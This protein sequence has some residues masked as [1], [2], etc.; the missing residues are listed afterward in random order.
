MPLDRD[1]GISFPDEHQKIS[2]LV[3][4]I[5][6]QHGDEHGLLGKALLHLNSSAIAHQYG[7][8]EEAQGKLLTAQS[9]VE[10]AMKHISDNTFQKFGT[11]DYFDTPEQK[12]EKDNR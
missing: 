12:E 6:I 4:Y 11:S 7:R 1:T 2:R 9:H 3:S 10:A 5:N 8:F